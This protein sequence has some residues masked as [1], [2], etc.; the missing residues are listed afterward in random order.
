MRATF[1]YTCCA[2]RQLST[3]L[4]PAL[5]LSEEERGASA[6]EALAENSVDIDPSGMVPKMT[7]WIAN[8]FLF[9]ALGG[10]APYRHSHLLLLLPWPWR[11]DSAVPASRCALSTAVA[12]LIALRCEDHLK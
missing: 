7:L 4:S 10:K 5:Y 6:A 8:P 3:S 11:E 1:E 9:G 12:S 2:G